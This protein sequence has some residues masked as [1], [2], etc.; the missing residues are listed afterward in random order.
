[1]QANSLHSDA[2]KSDREKVTAP[3]RKRRGAVTVT[4]TDCINPMVVFLPLSCS[5]Y[6]CFRYWFERRNTAANKSVSTGLQST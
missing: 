4:G 5:L 1:M 2:S 3:R 6:R